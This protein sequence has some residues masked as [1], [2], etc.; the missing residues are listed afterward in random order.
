MGHLKAADEARLD[1]DTRDVKADWLSR[2][3]DCVREAG[4]RPQ[5]AGPLAEVS[6]GLPG[7]P[8]RALVPGRPPPPTG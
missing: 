8:L 1:L 5:A 2:V 6:I 7:L 4:E 3:I